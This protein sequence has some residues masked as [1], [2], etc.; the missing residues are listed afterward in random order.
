MKN[1]NNLKGKI[2]N[3]EE[4]L[5]VADDADIEVRAVE[6]ARIDG[7]RVVSKED[8]QQA[9][10]ELSGNDEP[11]LGVDDGDGANSI[12]RDPSDPASDTGHQI[13]NRDSG[14][15]EFATERLVT[16]GV[17]E[18]DRDQMLAARKRKRE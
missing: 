3:H 5:A 18:A 14:D 17:N 15:E 7:H 2:L 8:R 12:S 11:S 16:E 6:I 4:G 9:A 1:I 10:S 13:P